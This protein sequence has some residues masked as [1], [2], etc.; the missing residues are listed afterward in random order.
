MKTY[1][2]TAR[3][4]INTILC[5]TAIKDLES[6]TSTKKNQIPI[7][8]LGIARTIRVRTKSNRDLL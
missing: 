2:E 4:I 6:A 5:D 8:Q 1:P 3:L 7:Q